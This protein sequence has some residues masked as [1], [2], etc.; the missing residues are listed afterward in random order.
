MHTSH[1]CVHAR[2]VKL[3]IL[4][5][6]AVLRSRTAKIVCECRPNHVSSDVAVSGNVH[7][8]ASQV[9]DYSTSWSGMRSHSSCHPYSSCVCSSYTDLWTYSKLRPIYLHVNSS[10]DC[11]VFHTSYSWLAGWWSSWPKLIQQ[12]MIV[13]VGLCRC[14]W[15]SYG[16]PRSMDVSR[17]WR[18][19]LKI[20]RKR[21]KMVVRRC[22]DLSDASWPNF[23]RM[24]GWKHDHRSSI[25]TNSRISCSS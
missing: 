6:Q 1:S 16:T 14:M 25:L 13:M 22:L 9:T 17:E 15:V 18:K 12:R 3:S 19:S 7:D 24:I 23:W 10:M 8:G 5:S 20:F 11:S 21:K 4:R 2:R